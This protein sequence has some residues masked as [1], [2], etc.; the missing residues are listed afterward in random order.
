[1]DR[2]N[3]TRRLLTGLAAAGWHPAF[4]RL[5]AVRSRPK[6]I[7]VGAGVAGAA[8][9]NAL[10]RAGLEVTVLEAAGRIGGRIHT[11]RDWGIPLELGANWVHYADDPANPVGGLL[12]QLGVA[13]GQTDYSSFR[14]FNPAG[15]K[16]GRLRAAL[17]AWKLETRLQKEV[18]WEH[19]GDY[20]LR[21]LVDRLYRRE[22][23]S[24]TR[25][26]LLDFAETAYANSL[27]ADLDDVSAGYYLQTE[28]PLGTDD[29]VLG[30]YDRL[31]KHLL[32]GVPVRLN[33]EVVEVRR[34]NGR[35]GVL[36]PAGLYEADFVLLTVPVSILQAGKI[37][38]Y[39]ELPAEKTAAFSRLRLGLFNK[40]MM[41]FAGKF[42]DGN[43]EFLILQQSLWKNG[44]ILLNYHHYG[45]QPI[46]V[47]MPVGEAARWVEEQAEET[48]ARVWREAFHRVYP[49]REIELEA[50]KVTR[51][52]ANP[53]SM[54]AYS[55]VPVG[56]SARDFQALA[57][58][59]GPI[60]FAG[61]ATV[62]EH[63]ATV[64]GAYL[65]GLR[66]ARRIVDATG[67]TDR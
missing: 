46:L 1:M 13:V 45:G 16:I 25:Q 7:V 50:L 3:F 23:L 47:A 21:E 10:L 32:E 4:A 44:G 19:G 34:E 52:Q 66:E 42:W 58:P 15:R 39:P 63:H 64:H 61:E 14:L 31:V 11:F 30:G 2:R 48:V 60:L 22:A 51:W 41:R 56:S 20:S 17:F 35:V 12:K 37:N 65:S 29:L 6:V 9:A 8:A 33:A 5:P 55:H 54:G 59:I 27:G 40:V 67:W 38:F 57:Q 53:F 62:A 49:R 18:P 26:A 43:P 36:T 24:S 28:E